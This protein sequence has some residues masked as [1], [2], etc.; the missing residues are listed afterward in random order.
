MLMNE[1]TRT[2]ATWHPPDARR[3]MPALGLGISL[4][5]LFLVARSVDLDDTAQI[6]GQVSVFPL[7]LAEAALLVALGLRIWIWHV[8][9]PYRADG[10]Q[11]SASR[12]TPVL[13]VSLLG[14][15]LLPARLGEVV[16]AYLISKR[17]RLSLGA[18]FG[19]VALQR[20]IDTATLAIIAFV[21]A[22]GTGA[23][24]WIVRGTGM[25]AAVGTALV[26]ALATIGIRPM[27]VLIG[28]LASV[29]ILRIPVSAAVRWLDPFV[30]WSGGA[31]RRPAIRKALALTAG[32]WMSNAAMFWLVGQA[33]GVSL[34]PIGYLLVM[35]VSV[36]ATAIPSAPAYVGTFELATVGVA[37]SLGVDGGP[38]LALALLA[39]ALSL[40][41][42]AIGGVAALASIGGGGLK[43]LSVAAIEERRLQ[44][45]P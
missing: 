9:L 32:T 40:L 33:L 3:V 5:A 24:N 25:L 4:L 31:H 35:S 38:A 15:L 14:N 36:L 20:V 17:E 1:P 16:G 28:R 45:E 12:F 13:L 39:H 19:S 43:R 18:A 34:S 27:V 22:T 8:L 21:G 26:I 42:A 23:A 44:A 30:Y 10:S 29:E 6:L 2:P 41:P 7:L 11:I 37:G